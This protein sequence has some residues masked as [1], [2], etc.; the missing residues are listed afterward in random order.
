MHWLF[1]DGCRRSC[2]RYMLLALPTTHVCGRAV[3]NLVVPFEF[4]VELLT[5]ISER[6]NLSLFPSNLM[7]SS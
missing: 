5:F 6:N 7:I 3:S 2:H 1:I 4:T